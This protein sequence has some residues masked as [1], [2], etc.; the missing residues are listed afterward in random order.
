LTT[1]RAHLCVSISDIVKRFREAT[2]APTPF[3]ELL[4]D[5]KVVDI[6][7][8]RKPRRNTSSGSRERNPSKEY[9]DDHREVKRKNSAASFISQVFTEE[10]RHQ[11]RRDAVLK[12]ALDRLELEM[13]RGQQAIS[14]AELAERR[15][16]EAEAR[17][18]ATETATL[19]DRHLEQELHA[20]RMQAEGLHHELRQ[21]QEKARVLERQ[22]EEAQEAAS[23]AREAARKHETALKDWQA[24]D[25]AKEEG[26]RIALQTE[27]EN[28]RREGWDAAHAEAFE[29]GHE[30]GFE[31]G[32]EQGFQ[33][34]R[35]DGFEDG[36][37]VGRREGFDDGYQQGRRE[38]RDEALVAFDRYMDEHGTPGRDSPRP[39]WIHR[40]MHGDT[41]RRQ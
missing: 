24:K 11:R 2:S 41:D 1:H 18:L 28:G 31:E 26:R 3:T 17:A 38:A 10:D 5:A 4:Q 6:L 14:R 36:R 8:E 12:N 39:G 13:R 37:Q 40:R 33:A 9:L 32:R 19:G 27:Y 22:K 7:S 20:L 29:E 23:R 35:I 34:G 21:A 25:D 16:A 15:A 30:N